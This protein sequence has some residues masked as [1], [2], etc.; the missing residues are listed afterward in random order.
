MV[1]SPPDSYARILALRSALDAVLVDALSLKTDLDRQLFTQGRQA[2][3]GATARDL[4]EAQARIRSLQSSLDASIAETSQ[5]RDR[6]QALQAELDRLR[7]V[8]SGTAYEDAVAR[9]GVLQSSFDAAMG[10]ARERNERLRQLEDELAELRDWERRSRD[11][12]YSDPA[13]LAELTGYEGDGE[14]KAGGEDGS[15]EAEPAEQQPAPE[16]AQDDAAILERWAA[17]PHRPK[18]VFIGT[19]KTGSLLFWQA[20]RDHP[21]TVTLAKDWDIFSANWADSPHFIEEYLKHYDRV[22]DGAPVNGVADDPVMVEMTSHYYA[23]PVVLQ[24]IAECCGRDV[25]IL[26]SIRNPITMAFSLYNNGLRQ[27]GW[28]KSFFEAVEHDEEQFFPQIPDVLDRIYS[29]FPKKNVLVVDYD[30]ESKKNPR[31]TVADALHFCGLS[32]YEFPLRYDNVSY[33]PRY[34]YNAERP[35]RIES[36]ERRYLIPPRTLVYCVGNG[37]ERVWYDPPAALVAA[38]LSVQSNWTQELSAATCRSLFDTH[39]R[40]MAGRLQRDF[41]IRTDHWSENFQTLR[42]QPAPPPEQFAIGEDE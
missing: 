34:L 22:V 11:G 4:E 30:L 23:D 39:C 3:G 26:F 17:L 21:R 35:L 42:Y 19:Q 28:P 1:E 8:Q 29:I 37:R 10:E 32:N 16:P 2:A 13:T 40:D 41:G 7:A 36:H 25:R 18:V 12:L 33:H 27:G 31:K 6:I 38:A 20:F 15:E 24:R 5:L 9:I 14:E